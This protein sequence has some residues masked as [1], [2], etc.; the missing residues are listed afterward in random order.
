MLQMC[1][2]LTQ[3]VNGL[4]SNIV[5]FCVTATLLMFRVVSLASPS[6]I[7]IAPPDPKLLDSIFTTSNTN[8]EFRQLRKGAAYELGA[9]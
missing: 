1:Q 2:L 5:V 7:A 6:A 3:Q 4:L 9:G 8:V